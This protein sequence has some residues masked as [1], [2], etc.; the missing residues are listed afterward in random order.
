[1]LYVTVLIVLALS[2][3]GV[4]MFI[5]STPPERK[6]S[7]N[8]IKK[9]GQWYTFSDVNHDEVISDD[10]FEQFDHNFYERLGNVNDGQLNT[11][12]R[13]FYRIW[14]EV[15]LNYQKEIS[16]D[17]FIEMMAQRYDLDQK[18]FTEMIRE[19]TKALCKV[20]DVNGDNF[21]SE[22]ESMT[23]LAAAG[24]NKMTENKKFF[25]TFQPKNGVIPVEKIITEFARSVTE[26]FETKPDLFEKAY[27]DL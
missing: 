9:W 26:K 15:I 1:M 24:H 17:D 4:D 14:K 20:I 16:K 3:S 5:R 10:D 25:M 18:A 13:R 7:R 19:F 8:L 12:K 11:I 21:I 27:T 6:A 23:D 22:E 2:C